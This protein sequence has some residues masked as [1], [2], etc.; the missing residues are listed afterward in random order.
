MKAS[1]EGILSRTASTGRSG[2][3]VKLERF[4]GVPLV[5]KSRAPY[6]VW[7]SVPRVMT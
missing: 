5:R 2:L 7:A 1:I 6:P 3:I 4:F